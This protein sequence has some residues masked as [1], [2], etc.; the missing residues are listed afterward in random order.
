MKPAE[1]RERILAVAAEVVAAGG[2]FPSN[3]DLAEVAGC[4]RSG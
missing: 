1:R 2:V 3:T 4:G